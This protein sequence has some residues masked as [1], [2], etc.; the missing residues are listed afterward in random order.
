MQSFSAEPAR[1]HYKSHYTARIHPA[2]TSFAD[3]VGGTLA[4]L[5]AYVVTL[6]LL[7]MGGMALWEQLPDLAAMDPSSRDASLKDA[8]LKDVWSLVDRSSRAF[9]VSQF[10]PHD[11]TEAYEIFRHPRAAAGMSSCGAAETNSRS[12]NS[13]SIARAATSAMPAC[14]RIG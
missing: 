5:V 12:P 1:S 3:E 4:R 13:R 6:A 7:A 14:R 10:D 8:S 2:L 11:K 9:A